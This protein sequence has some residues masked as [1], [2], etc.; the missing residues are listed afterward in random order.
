MNWIVGAL[1]HI[2]GKVKKNVGCVPPAY[3]Q[4]GE[5]TKIETKVPIGSIKGGVDSMGLKVF[6]ILDRKTCSGER[7]RRRT[8]RK[9]GLG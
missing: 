5:R 1:E 9:S 4:A 2:E 7:S 6:R 8:R 3:R